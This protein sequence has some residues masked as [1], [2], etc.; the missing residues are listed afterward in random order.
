MVIDHYACV[1]YLTK[2]AAKS[3]PRSPILRQ[4]FN[5]VVQS[6]GADN[7]PHKTIKRVVMKTLGERNY[8]AQET[9]HHLLSLKLHSSTYSVIPICLN[10]SRKVHTNVSE[11]DDT[12]TDYLHLDVYANRH[13]YNKSSEVMNM[14]FVQFATKY[15]FQTNTQKL[16]PLPQNVVPRIF[17]TYSSNPKGEHFA[18]YCKY[19]LFRDRMLR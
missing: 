18:S 3:E 14:N 7:N 1:E 2:Y 16:V 11:D 10:G 4:A 19:Q 17:S 8:A 13:Q 6:S 12:C 15:K 9:M 5:S